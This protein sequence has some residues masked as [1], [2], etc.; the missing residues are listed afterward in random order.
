MHTRAVLLASLT[1]LGPFTLIA[2]AGGDDG[3]RS[4]ADA[5]RV[6]VQVADTELGETDASLISQVKR[7][8][9]ATQVS[10]KD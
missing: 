9:G 4:P 1:S 3:E 10:Y 8:E 5:Q 7:A 2:C 6:M